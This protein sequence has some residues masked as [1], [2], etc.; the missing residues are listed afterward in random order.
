MILNKYNWYCNLKHRCIYTP[1]VSHILCPYVRTYIHTYVC[2]YI[3]TFVQLCHNECWM[4]IMSSI[5]KYTQYLHF[6]ILQTFTRCTKINMKIAVDRK[7][8]NCWNIFFFGTSCSE[9]KRK[10][11]KLENLI[12]LLKILWLNKR[13]YSSVSVRK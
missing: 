3:W 6:K 12:F 11:K 5:Y 13:K 7:R 8:A 2:T 9:S 4:S 10:C 1:A